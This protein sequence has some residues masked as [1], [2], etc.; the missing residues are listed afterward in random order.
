M[1]HFSLL[2]GT[3]AERKQTGGIDPW[4]CDLPLLLLP[5][6][7]VLGYNQADPSGHAPAP[8]ALHRILFSHS[9]V[10]SSW[11]DSS[12]GLT[13]PLVVVMECTRTPTPGVL[14][15]P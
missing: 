8:P 10:T 9:A 5:S 15:L 2:K 7:F 13:F 3:E 11:E 1:A 4:A 14:I 6:A 12:F